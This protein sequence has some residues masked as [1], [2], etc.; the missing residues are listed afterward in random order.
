[1]SGDDESNSVNRLMKLLN[2][3]DA[4]R[5]LF[6]QRGAI[7]RCCR[8]VWLPPII[9]IGIRSLALVKTDSAYVFYMERCVL[10]M[11]SLLW[12][13]YILELYIFLAQLHGL[14]SVETGNFQAAIV[15]CTPF[16][17][18]GVGRGAHYAY[19][20]IGHNSKLR[21][22]EAQKYFARPGNRTRDP[23]SG[24]RTCDHL[25]NEAVNT[26]EEA[27]RVREQTSSRPSR[28]E[29]HSGRRGSRDDLR[30]PIK[31]QRSVHRK[32]FQS[33]NGPVVA[34][35]LDFPANP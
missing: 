9:F 25:T 20:H 30:P 12:M 17:P 26:K 7:L 27:G 32:V 31:V 2:S 14:V 33:F 16:S 18:E 8:C 28:R 10:W 5:V 24:S 34:I 1:M 29:R 22:T 13:H 19:C 6:Q 3:L 15:V 4:L 21:T 35:V 23:L 11:A